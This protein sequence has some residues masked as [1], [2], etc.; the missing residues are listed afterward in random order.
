MSDSEEEVIWVKDGERSTASGKH[1]VEDP[2]GTSLGGS[3]RRTR[4]NSTA[5]SASSSVPSIQTAGGFHPHDHHDFPEEVSN[6]QERQILLIM[7]LAQVCALHDPTPRTFTV[8]V[9]ELF[10]R[11]ILDRDSIRFL[12]ELGLVPSISPGRALLT[13]GRADDDEGVSSAVVLES[14]LALP[15]VPGVVQQQLQRSREASAIRS[16]LSQSQER[17]RPE[18]DNCNTTNAT[19]AANTED[20]STWDVANFPLSLSRYQ[21]EFTQVALLNSGSFGQVFQAT[22]KMDG[23]DYAI[24]KIAFNAVGYS[25]ETIQTVVRE[26]QCLATV[27][28]HPN[29]VRYYTSWLEPSWMTGSGQV[30]PNVPQHKLLTDLQQLMHHPGDEKTTDSLCDD[31]GAEGSSYF[32]REFS[33]FGQS[34]PGSSGRR[35]RRFSFDSSVESADGGWNSYRD[36]RLSDLGFAYEDSYLTTSPRKQQKENQQQ[37]APT[38]Q[39][40][41]YRYQICLYIQM[42]LCQ[43]A[44]LADWIRERNRQVPEADHGLRI[45]PALDIFEQIV[46]GLAHVHAKGIIHRDLKPSNIFASEDGKVVKIGDFGLSKQM[47]GLSRNSDE[48][49]TTP[50][51]APTSPTRKTP[52]FE[53]YWQRNEFNGAMVPHRN[54]QTQA[55]VEYGVGGASRPMD[56][57]TAGV[58][59]A[60]YAS[61]EQVKSRSYGTA[62]DIFSVGLILLELVSCF[63][64]EH[65]RLH[66]FQQCRNQ[67]L[68]ACITEHYPDIGDAILSCTRNDPSQRPLARDLLKMMVARRSSKPH[69][70]VH[71]LKGQ[72]I[73][74]EQQ[75]EQHKQELAEKNRIIETMR[76]EMERMRTSQS[77]TSGE[78]GTTTCVQVEYERI[79]V[80]ATTSTEEQD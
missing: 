2:S 67:C 42:Q 17:Q 52:T 22:R 10:E 56:P 8:H 72:L 40:P 16:Q 58:G 60:S 38:P 74:K 55:L 64:T 24:K 47:R 61:P 7:L 41:T 43:P 44:T 11:G 31:T 18:N 13:N 70:D 39:S 68:P 50:A 45:E 62:A 48:P 66:N 77:S 5:S 69:T 23:C 73:E 14:Q 9:L 79:V 51:S 54:N 63:E 33:S 80:E 32:S 59:T 6:D 15:V 36:P 3:I 26:V 28:D 53:K 30:E 21:R 75:L 27:S 19:D 35:R 25:N 20:T 12:F 57:L 37:P 65:E 1:V 76:L 71:V 34:R 46:N 78:N 4:A 29:I 49:A